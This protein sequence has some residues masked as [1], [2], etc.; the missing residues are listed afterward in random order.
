MLTGGLLLFNLLL[1]PRLG[2]RSV[3]RARERVRG[4]SGAIVAYPAV[5]VIAVLL[6][7][8]RLEL[9]AALWALLAFG[10]GA[11]GWIGPRVRTRP[12]PWNGAKTLGGSIAFA[13]AGWAGSTAALWWTSPRLEPWS[14]VLLA[15]G[16]G[17]AVAAAVESLPGSLDDN[18]TAPLSGA[19][20]LALT[21]ESG[22]SLVYLAWLTGGALVAWA[23]VRRRWLSAD[24]GIAAAVVAGGIGCGLGGRGW[25]VLGLF[26]LVG[27][28]VSRPEGRGDGSGRAGDQVLANGLV[29]ATAGLLFASGAAQA[30]RLA[31][32]AALTEAAADTVSGEV[33]QRLGATARLVTTWRRVPAGT[34]GA[35]SW[36]GTAVG[37]GVAGA[38]ALVT[39]ALGLAA[40]VEAAV[41]AG[42][43]SVGA[44]LD[45]W[46]GATLERSGRWDNQAVNLVST[47]AA[48]LLA[49]WWT[50]L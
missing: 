50:T 30:W 13:V 44:G 36:P 29:A 40:P 12:L 34:D 10:D 31:A 3:W 37:L 38:F 20:V 9:A 11:A 48:A 8:H 7:R 27:V 24:G 4:A 43:G 21:L 32:L 47:A 15:A 17:S 1:W 49:A 18:W 19:A 16:L 41:I 23:A 33:G 45:S 2:G 6:F 46:L 42:A 25:I 5:L 22:G 39:L 26:F 14:L 35:V 28:A